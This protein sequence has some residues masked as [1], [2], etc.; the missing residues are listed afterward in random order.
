MIQEEDFIWSY[1]VWKLRKFTLTLLKKFVNVTCLLNKL[2]KSWFHEIFLG[3]SKFHVFPHCAI[4]IVELNGFANIFSH[5]YLCI[6]ACLLFSLCIKCCS[7]ENWKLQNMNCKHLC[8]QNFCWN[9][10]PISLLKTLFFTYLQK[11]CLALIVIASIDKIKIWFQVIFM[12]PK[13]IFNWIFF[14]NCLTR[15]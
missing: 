13:L 7:T 2:E 15:I 8:L 12:N 14:W 5:I 3:E 6:F 4:F 11:N 10:L 1:T 9:K